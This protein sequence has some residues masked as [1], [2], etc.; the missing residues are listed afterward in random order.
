SGLY[1]ITVL[2]RLG[3]ADAVKAKAVLTAG[4]KE[5]VEAVAKGDAEIGV[6]FISEIIAVKGA[7]YAGPLPA[8]LQDYTLYTAAV[9]KASKDPGS[10][11]AYSEHVV[12]GAMAPRWK[13]AGF[14]PPR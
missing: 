2:N 13:A 10:G 9:P 6:A 11:R 12:A 14:E 8:A 7:K 4:G 5:T 3:V 1:F